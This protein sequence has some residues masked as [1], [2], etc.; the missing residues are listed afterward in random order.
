MTELEIRTLLNNYREGIR[1]LK[2]A[3]KLADEIGEAAV[4][5]GSPTPRIDKVISSPA[6]RARF[7]DAVAK[8]YEMERV[9]Y[10]DAARLDAERRKAERLIAL[11]PSAVARV[12]MTRYYLQGE[13]NNQIART[14]HYEVRTI[15]RI[16][17][18]A[19][20]KICK[21]CSW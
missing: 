13:S 3:L 6:L 17:Q 8:K 14:M 5:T 21:K 10:E 15:Q 11:A 19:I 18:K 2:A 9:I 1:D 7:E 4:A 16:K 12:V 20:R